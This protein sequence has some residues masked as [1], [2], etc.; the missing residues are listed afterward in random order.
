MI[1]VGMATV[2]ICQP[3]LLHANLLLQIQPNTIN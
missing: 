3:V 2:E 1:A